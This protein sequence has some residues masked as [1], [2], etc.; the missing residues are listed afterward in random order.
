M[1]GDIRLILGRFQEPSLGGIGVGCSF[2]SGERLGCDQEEGSFGIGLFKSFHNV[3]SINVGDEVN[4]EIGMAVWLQSLRYHDRTAGRENS[5]STLRADSL[6]MMMSLQ[7]RASYTNVDNSP[8]LLARITLPFTAPHLLCKFLHMFE[9]RVDIWNNTLAIDLHGLVG[10]IA[11]SNVVDS[12]IFSEVDMVTTEHVIAEL[13]H[14][15]LLGQLHQETHGFIGDQILGEIEENIRLICGVGESVRELLE[16]LWVFLK[17]F[18]EN[19]VLSETNMMLLELSEGI[20]ISGLRETGH[21]GGIRFFFPCRAIVLVRGIS[22][23]ACTS[24]FPF[25]FFFFLDNIP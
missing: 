3:R 10:D 21:S 2:G 4:R 7:V 23:K 8:D 12:P 13:L 1:F 18:L 11:Q 15:R 9:F 24:L 16:T 5:K 17:E 19:N 6:A 25:F 20:Q 22:E 14:V